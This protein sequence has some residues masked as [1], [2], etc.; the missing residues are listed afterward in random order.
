MKERLWGFRTCR[1]WGRVSAGRQVRDLLDPL[2]AGTQDNTDGLWETT[3]PADLSLLL[4]LQTDIT[5]NPV[6]TRRKSLHS[7]ISILLM[8]GWPPHPYSQPRSTRTNS[9][10]S[11]FCRK[12]T[13]HQ[14]PTNLI[15]TNATRD[16]RCCY[17]THFL[18]T[19]SENLDGLYHPRSLSFMDS[20]DFSTRTLRV[21][22]QTQS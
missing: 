7:I 9:S 20:N 12:S 15:P 13:T 1:V 22:Q 2:A 21:F 4:D 3:F 19:L 10:N 5:N 6:K 8:T 11:K 16:R 18:Q 17:S 14:S